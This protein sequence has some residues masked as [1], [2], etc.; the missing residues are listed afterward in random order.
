MV[1]P[2][3]NFLSINTNYLNKET[4]NPKTREREIKWF[5]EKLKEAKA[6]NKKVLIGSHIPLAH[7][8]DYDNTISGL[9]EEYKDTI[10]I[11]LCGH[12]H[13]LLILVSEN[14]S[15]PYGNEIANQAL[16]PQDLFNPGFSIYNY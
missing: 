8:G 15:T 6:E 4:R 9:L 5:K 12:L 2:E 13:D 10:S 14:K 3:V 16:S 11:S 1:L 7:T